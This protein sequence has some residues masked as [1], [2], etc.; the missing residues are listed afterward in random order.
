MSNTTY[1][2]EFIEALYRLD[3]CRECLI[4]SNGD[5]DAAMAAADFIISNQVPTIDNISFGMVGD[6]WHGP[7]PPGIDWTPIAD[8]PKGGKRWKRSLNT[9]DNNGRTEPGRTSSGSD[10]RT[11]GNR[12]S[13]NS[14]GDGA[15][16]TNRNPTQ[17]TTN[18][19]R[20]P[21]PIQHPIKPTIVT[22]RGNYTQD[23]DLSKVPEKLRKYLVSPDGATH[24]LEGAAA[25][26]NAVDKVGGFLLADGAGAGKTRQMLAVAQTYAMR[27]KKAVIVAPAGIIKPDWDD[28]SI[29]GSI[30]KDGAAM[31]IGLKLN[32]GEDE[33]HS[34]D[35]CVTTYESLGKIKD[36]IDNDTVVIFDEAHGLKNAT[37]ARSAHGR[38][39]A[40]KAMGVVYGTATPADDIRN[41]SYLFRTKLFGDEPWTEVKKRFNKKKL[42][43]SE[44]MKNVSNIFSKLT[45]DGIMI[46][47]EISLDGVE[48]NFQHVNLP[49]E[50]KDSLEKMKEDKTLSRGQLLMRQRFAQERYKIKNVVDTVSKELAEGRQVVVFVAGVGAEEGQLGTAGLLKEALAKT[51]N[52]SLKEVAEL[53]GAEGGG[54]R[55]VVEA[56][57]NGSARVLIT[58]P[59]SGGTG[60]NFDDVVGDKPRTQVIVTPPFSAIDNSQIWG[61]TH[62]LTTKS[63]SRMHYIFADTKIDKWNADLIRNKMLTLSAIVGGETSKQAIPDEPQL[64]QALSI[65]KHGREHKEKGTGGGQFVSKKTSNINNY[66]D[67][68]KSDKDPHVYI[69]TGNPEVD[70][71]HSDNYASYYNEIANFIRDLGFKVA[72]DKG[73]AFTTPPS[74]AQFWIGHSRGSDRLRFGKEENVD[75]LSLDEY[76]PTRKKQDR[77]YDKLFRKLKVTRIADIPID[78]RPKPGPEHY[79]FNNKQKK[80][81]LQLLLSKQFD[82]DSAALGLIDGKWH[83]LTPPSWGRWVISTPGP[84][85]GTIW[86]R[87]DGRSNNRGGRGRDGSISSTEDRGVEGTTQTSGIERTNRSGNGSNQPNSNQS[88]QDKEFTK[89]IN[90]R[91][92]AYKSYFRRFKGWDEAVQWIDSL[93][94]HINDVGS[95]IALNELLDDSNLTDKVNRVQYKGVDKFEKP[96]SGPDKADLNFITRYLDHVGITFLPRNAKRDKSIPLIASA[97][98]TSAIESKQDEDIVAAE[99]NWDSKLV[100]AKLLPGL[101]TTEDIHKLLGYKVDQITPIVMRKLDRIYGKDNWV[102]KNY[103]EESLAGFG[104]FF[105]QRCRQIQENSRQILYESEIQLKALGYSLYD[106]DGNIQKPRNATSKVNKLYDSAISASINADGVKLPNTSEDRLLQEYGIRLIVN[107][108]GEVTG[109]IEKDGTRVKRGS[110]KWNK[111]EEWDSGPGEHTISRAITA[112]SWYGPSSGY[113]SGLKYMVQPAFDSPLVTEADRREGVTWETGHEARV[114]AI[115]DNGKVTII[116]YTTLASRRDTFPTVFYNDDIKEMEK[117]V[118]K[119]LRGLPRSER[120]G[121]TYGVDVLKTSDGWKV[122]ETNPSVAGGQS[123]WLRRNPFVIDAFVSYLTNREPAH[124]KFIRDVL[125]NREPQTTSTG[126]ISASID[127]HGRVH[128]PAGPGGGQFVSNIYSGKS[129]TEAYSKAQEQGHIEILTKKDRKLE[130]ELEEFPELQIMNHRTGASV[131]FLPPDIQ[132]IKNEWNESHPD[133]IHQYEAGSAWPVLSGQRAGG[134]IVGQWINRMEKTTLKE[135]EEFINRSGVPNIVIDRFPRG[136]IVSNTKKAKELGLDN[137]EDFREHWREFLSGESMNLLGGEKGERITGKWLGFPESSTEALLQATLSID[138]HGREHAPAGTDKGGQFVKKHENENTKNTKSIKD[139]KNTNSVWQGAKIVEIPLGGIIMDEF[140]QDELDAA[141]PIDPKKATNLIVT[142]EG[143][144]TVL[145]DGQEVLLGMIKWCVENDVDLNTINAY[146]VYATPEVKELIEKK[147]KGIEQESVSKESWWSRYLKQIGK[148]ALRRVIFRI[149]FPAIAGGLSIDSHGREHA[150]AGSGKGGQFISKPTISYSRARIKLAGGWFAEDTNKKVRT[151]LRRFL[152][153]GRTLQDFATVVGAPDDAVVTIK[154]PKHGNEVNIFTKHK[155]FESERSIREGVTDSGEKYTWIYNKEIFIKPEFQGEGLGTDIFYKQVINASNMGVKSIYATG[156]YGNTLDGTKMNGFY[157]LPRYGYNCKID[158]MHIYPEEK[159]PSIKEQFPKARTIQDIYKT[160]EGRDWWKK[161]GTWLVDLEF[162]LTP[163]SKSIRHLTSYIK[164]KEK[165]K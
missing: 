33:I 40:T 15:D 135:L 69:I 2:D 14:E 146:V 44:V 74:G 80:A 61:R 65:D 88:S 12:G 49:Q 156:G 124:V 150:P 129:S 100:E 57:Q 59:Q 62:R 90:K 18:T 114:H 35:V 86:E 75:T 132:K 34:G 53:H 130:I 147:I 108:D 9:R 4:E 159:L 94:K 30:N 82:I 96:L 133:F 160:P 67:K 127:V 123:M 143:D 110:K 134:L 163:N 83:G 71:E 81:I 119:T 154:I 102:I 155:K 28:N 56:F 16:S 78:M 121:Q 120:V 13:E 148:R 142:K 92:D 164:A 105:P 87:A 165:A 162:D 97:P 36:K 42:G 63:A 31:G 37:S 55:E 72:F 70:T 11:N 41:I 45:E 140:T 1:S 152:G 145:L 77:E 116:P 117:V 24:Q 128:K 26:I 113:D 85:G 157:T 91:L 137:Y 64:Q 104:V 111:L 68:L 58:T 99:T 51:G 161:N 8:G 139:I 95:D 5:V 46:K 141:E 54:G 126:G 39:V 98:I 84:R 6:E 29:S 38:E 52:I 73:E 20:I 76:E 151:A 17:Q 43:A 7:K 144:D 153:K 89:R 93:Q 103:G 19:E 23:I 138:S 118:Q 109:L 149:L 32:N 115:T 101:E 112:M 122:V 47:R 10:V 50:L 60:H 79:T 107:K 48:A 25:A 131:Y 136:I 27:G 22:A 106:P 66:Y 158:D 21:G 3:V 125:T